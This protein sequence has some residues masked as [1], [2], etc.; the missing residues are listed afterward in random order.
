MQSFLTIGLLVQCSAGK[1]KGARETMKAVEPL[2][3]SNQGERFYK[4][5][6]LC[7]RIVPTWCQL[8][9]V[10]AEPPTWVQ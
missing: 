3:R 1:D 8:G 10:R 4:G 5:T 6:N 9:M 2:K 7:C